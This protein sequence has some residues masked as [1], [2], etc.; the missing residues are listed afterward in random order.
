MRKKTLLANMSMWMN[1]ASATS[2]AK[3]RVRKARLP[4]LASLFAAGVVVSGLSLSQANAA[5]V[6]VNGTFD[7]L[8]GWTGA[9]VNQSG[10]GTFPDLDTADYYWGGRTASNA[11]TQSYM[12]TPGEL[13]TLGTSGLDFTMSADL[14]GFSVQADF[15]SFTAEFLDGGMGSL[16]S[17]TLVST[18]NDPGSWAASYTAGTA[19]IFQSLAG[20]IPTLTTSILFTV[21]SERLSG[22]SNDGYL[23]NAFFELSSSNVSEVPVPAAFP[24][25][26][27]GLG[28][29]GLLGW[30][31]KRKAAAA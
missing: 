23:D 9:W 21:A 5:N 3:A 24:L 1:G 12:L 17:Q 11:I 20:T 27:G 29:M 28:L 8:S 30:R 26:A 14:F 18:T 4:R 6:I 15:S 19:P 2:E 22:S 25:L 16:G 31:R 10:A 13:L 7:D